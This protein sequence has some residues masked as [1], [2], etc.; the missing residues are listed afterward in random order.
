[1]V[2]RRDVS[3]PRVLGALTSRRPLLSTVVGLVTG[4][5]LT[6]PSGGGRTY[7]DTDDQPIPEPLAPVPVNLVAK[8][9]GEDLVNDWIRVVSE[10][11][12]VTTPTHRGVPIEAG[13]VLA[14]EGIDC[15]HFRS[16]S[17]MASGEQGALTLRL[18]LSPDGGVTWFWHPD[19][20][21][22]AAR[23]PVL[24]GR[25]VAPQCRVVVENRHSGS[26]VVQSWLTLAR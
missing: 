16:Y 21:S 1:M 2:G 22:V 17:V 11:T 15:S 4:G 24:S 9:A 8:L 25:I 12:M 6:S 19:G 20:E 26:Q 10:P 18:E 5:A 13:T 14:S 3:F 7:Q 23:F